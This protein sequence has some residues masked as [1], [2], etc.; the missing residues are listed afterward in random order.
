MKKLKGSIVLIDDDAF[1]KELLHSALL[2]LDWDAKVEYF[3]SGKAALDY[4]RTTDDRIFV[5]ISDMNMPEMNGLQLK[6]EIDKDVYLCRK[7]IPFVFSSNAATKTEITEAYD[8]RV[9]GYF[10]KPSDMK[11]MAE[12]VDTIIRYWII[13]RHPND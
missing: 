1:E 2:R 5:I 9:Q 4:L 7:A 13:S 6:K 12:L 8:Y 10:K 3:L 11:G